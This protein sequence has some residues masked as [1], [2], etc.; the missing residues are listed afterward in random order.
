MWFMH[1]WIVWEKQASRIF[2]NIKNAGAVQTHFLSYFLFLEFQIR[3][4]NFTF[5]GHWTPFAAA[6]KSNFRKAQPA[7]AWVEEWESYAGANG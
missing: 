5:L 7:S 1:I 2:T 4:R 3:H 6:V